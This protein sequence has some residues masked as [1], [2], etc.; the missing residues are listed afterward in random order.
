MNSSQATTL[1]SNLI[2]QWIAAIR[3]RDFDWLERNLAED[4]LFS[5]HPFPELRLGKREFI[6][7]DKKIANA[8][9]EFASIKGEVIGEIIISTAVADVKAESFSAE[10]GHGLPAASE[11][12]Q[13]L[14]GRRLVY[15]SAW[16]QG[17]TGWQCYDHHLFGFCQ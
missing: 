10:L 9:L 16:R 5:A 8:E 11:M 4:F 7:L 15:S 17:S 3:D 1:V 6:D 13:M 2:R 14:G 12:S